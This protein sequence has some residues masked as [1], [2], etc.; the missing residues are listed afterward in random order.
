MEPKMTTGELPEDLQLAIELI[1]PAS[2]DEA[3]ELWIESE[4]PHGDAEAV[5]RQWEESRQLLWLLQANKATAAIH[6]MHAANVAALARVDELEKAR[7]KLASHVEQA[8][9][10]MRMPL[11][12][13]QARVANMPLLDAREMA[14]AMLNQEVT[15][16]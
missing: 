3:F 6:A 1:E 2:E 9:S 16:G 13:A 10:T 4:R 7:D 11:A 12:E 5:H 14:V 15:R 8:E